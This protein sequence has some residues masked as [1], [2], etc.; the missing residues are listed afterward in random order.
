MVAMRKRT[1]RKDLFRSITHSWSRFWAIFAIVALGAGFFAGLRATGPDMRATGDAYYDASNVMDIQLL[2]TMGFTEDDIE[3]VKQTDGVASVMA[4]HQ[5]DVMSSIDGEEKVIRIHGLPEADADDPAYMNRPVLTSGRM[6]ENPGECVIGK[7]KISFSELELGSVV[8]LEDKD[9]TLGDTIQYTEY[10]VVG[11]VDDAYYLSYTLGNTS[12]G[13]GT[14]SCFMYV[15]D[16]DF[17]VDVYTDVYVTISGAQAL[18]AFSAQYD[19]LIA[20][21]TDAFQALADVRE[22]VRYDEVERDA[23]QELADAQQ[24]Y[25]DARKDADEQLADAQ[26]ELVDAQAEIDENEQK[27]ADA[28][29]QI[30]KNERKLNRAASEIAD[31]EAQLTA[32]QQEYDQNEAAL[33]AAWDE[34]DANAAALTQQRQAWQQAMDDITAG[35]AALDEAETAA[36]GDPAA[37]AAIAAQRQQLLDQQTA[38]L[39][40]EPQL[41]AAQDTLDATYVTLA[42]S[43]QQLDLFEAQLNAGWVQ[44]DE[45]KAQ[46]KQGRAAL[47]DAKQQYQDGMDALADAKQQL[48]DGQ[49]DY[50]QAKAD[51]ETELADAQEKIDE[52]YEQLND[53]KLPTWYVLDRGDNAGFASFKADTERM[54]SLSSVFPVIFFLVAAL[55]A[56]TTMTRMVDEE[57][58]VI[59][60]YKALGYS[61]M[62]IASKYLIYALIASL[63]GGTLGVAVGFYTLPKVCWN[64]YLL[65]Y[66][67]PDL[68]EQ[69]NVGYA[70]L[71]VAA[72]TLCTLI[73]TASVCQSTLASTPAALMLP[74]APKAGKRIWLERIPFIWKRMSFTWKVTFRNLFRYKKRLI[75]TVVGI[76]GCT[77]LLLTGFG[78]R[79]SISNMLDYQYGSICHFDTIIGLSEDSLSEEAE[80]VINERM[81]SWTIVSSHAEQI[82]TADGESEV[83]GYI[84]VPKDRERLPEFITLR[85]RVTRKPVAFGSGA[86]VLTEKV[87]KTLGLTAGDEIA[88]KNDDGEL[89]DFTVTGVTENYIYQYVYIDPELYAQKM[90]EAPE[91]N[92]VIA[93]GAGKEGPERQALSD[94]LMNSEGVATVMF[95]E[96]I[97]EKF[98]K[99]IT[100]LNAI[101]VVLIVCAGALAFVVLYNLTNIN[102]LERKREIATIKVLGFF[103]RE[104]TAYIYRETTLL[105]LLGCAIGLGAGVFMHA[106]VI[107]TI[108]VDNVMFARDIM[109]LSFLWSVLLTLAFSVFV[110]IVMY[111]KLRNVSMTDNLKSVD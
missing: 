33:E 16:S 78:I 22:Q 35:L 74:R 66:T 30:E 42:Q 28:Q 62:K 5:V 43:Q 106:F 39:A 24:E 36:A 31:N 102:V 82:Y 1:F 100:S 18:S 8:T 48:A 83:S 80:A 10:T 85:D 89:V 3:L 110:D 13:S 12:I 88:V 90:G 81:E 52:G 55:V 7:G 69:F 29:E 68:I 70:V 109:P 75:M 64:A 4:V 61:D 84:Y 27:L 94:E 87:A 49:A 79:D 77:S 71:G 54:D 104:V 15:P 21:R 60:T 50:E 51:A 98:D 103:D 23:E 96:D 38:L 86:V 92:G 58:L 76:A 40:Q 45:A 2:S 11:F 26:Q 41:Q 105:T 44:L 108:E 34:Y 19:E 56:L 63:T 91:Y 97:T 95:T 67:A 59:G 65:M 47:N 46:L 107:Q 101:V 57:R 25:D 17:S 72:A 32:S 20:G 111:S 73:A 99:M 14:V 93:A 9:G 6:P 37:L 53:L